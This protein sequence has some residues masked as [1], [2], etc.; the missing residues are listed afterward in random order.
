MR[1]V[2]LQ[3]LCSTP[4]ALRLIVSHRSV[5]SHG[6][7]EKQCPCLRCRLPFIVAKGLPA[8]HSLRRSCFPEA[9]CYSWF[10]LHSQK[11]ILLGVA[12]VR[13]AV[14]PVPPVFAGLCDFMLSCF[15]LCHV[16]RP[17]RQPAPW[18]PVKGSLASLGGSLRFS[19]GQWA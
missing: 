9:N 5:R 14:P 8:T 4:K 3:F 11:R 1:I 12:V 13:V 15:R 19:E 2:I 10:T 16:N 17:L 7:C 18:G 6:H